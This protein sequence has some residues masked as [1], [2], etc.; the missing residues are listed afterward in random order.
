ME[1]PE[2]IKKLF[3]IERLELVTSLV[4]TEKKGE[5]MS[6]AALAEEE[7]ATFLT[8]YL[9]SPSHA[10]DADAKTRTKATF[11]EK[12]E[13]L[14]RVLPKVDSTPTNYKAHLDFLHA[15]RN[16]RNVAA[17]GYSLHKDKLI[18]LS[19]DKAMLRIGEDFPKNVWTD[20][21]A[22]RD[23]LSAIPL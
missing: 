2:D 18:E 6:L 9:A 23:Y 12:I 14:E 16:L 8:R 3:T 10:N 5:L 20:V 22:L 4:G 19:S 21:R 15:L 7:V 17:H 13:A 1:I 11:N